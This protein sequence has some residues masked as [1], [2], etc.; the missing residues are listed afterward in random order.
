MLAYMDW[1]A[2]VPATYPVPVA[3]PAPAEGFGLGTG[4]D[5]DAVAVAAEGRAG[6][7]CAPMRTVSSDGTCFT[8]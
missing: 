7:A 6:M 5:A 3:A 4:E 1:A 8:S 2:D